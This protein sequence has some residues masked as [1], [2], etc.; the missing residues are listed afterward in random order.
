MAV[1]GSTLMMSSMIVIGIL[2]GLFFSI[3]PQQSLFVAACLSLSS[4]PLVSKFVDNR[5]EDETLKG[6]CNESYYY[7]LLFSIDKSTNKLNNF[8]HF[9]HSL[10]LFLQ[11]STVG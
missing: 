5:N 2:W 6:T 7:S 8:I 10:Y 11:Y 4:T 1:G 9:P 3:R